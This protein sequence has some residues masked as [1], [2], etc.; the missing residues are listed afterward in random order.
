[1][2]F[3]ITPEIFAKLK[4]KLLDTNE[5]ALTT[6]TPASGSMTSLD[7]KIAADFNF[8]GTMLTVELTRHDGYF[9]WVANAG[10]KSKLSAAIAGLIEI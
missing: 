9:G 2:T 1:M 4:A 3:T 10:L 8:D 7:G 5:V 6:T